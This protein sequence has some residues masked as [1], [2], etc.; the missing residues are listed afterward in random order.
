MDRSFLSNAAVVEASRKLVCVRLATYEDSEEAKFL[1][2]IYGSTLANTVFTI[3]APDGETPL[4][5]PSRG[6]M[7]MRPSQL[8]TTLDR[9]AAE[10]NSNSETE[11]KPRSVPELKSL[12]L[13][14]NVASCDYLQLVV[15][16]GKSKEELKD[17][18]EKVN[19]LAWH[20]DLAGQFLF[21]STTSDSDLRSLSGL[22][23]SKSG[24]FIVEP[25]PYGLLGKVIHQC[26]DA[27]FDFGKLTQLAKD[28]NP[29][30]KNHGA[31]TKLGVSMGFRW[32]TETPVTDQQFVR[33]TERLWGEKYEHKKPEPDEE[34]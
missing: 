33:A 7:R 17:L 2:K 16:I 26:D 10:Y 1:R 28:Y 12:D 25:D 18:Q 5:R 34:K 21:V 19:S 15:T 6:P 3:L 22:P 4:I 20:K 11:S 24:I 27:G 14:L 13:A 9:Y 32:D 8:A 29:A 30:P 23:E 31:H